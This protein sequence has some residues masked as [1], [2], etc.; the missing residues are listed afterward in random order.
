VCKLPA[1]PQRQLAVET[2]VN[3][4]EGAPSAA[5][6]SASAGMG[7]KGGGGF[8]R[9]Y[10]I[11]AQVR[12]VVAD[13]MSVRH[14]GAELTFRNVPAL[15]I[16]DNDLSRQENADRHSSSSSNDMSR[17]DNAALSPAQEA[18]GWGGVAGG[19]GGGAGLVGGDRAR[20]GGRLDHSGLPGHTLGMCR[21]KPG[22]SDVCV[23]SE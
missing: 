1:I 12:V 18:Q 22:F 11:R 5:S 10:S 17:Q 6:S 3:E 20:I 14:S 8:V 2:L 19:A 15:H 9:G 4:L 16:C 13:Q 7:G 23:G 21:T